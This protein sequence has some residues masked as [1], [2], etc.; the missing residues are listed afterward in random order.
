MTCV[1]Y[2]RNYNFDNIPYQ[3]NAFNNPQLAQSVYSTNNHDNNYHFNPYFPS[4]TNNMSACRSSVELGKNLRNSATNISEAQK[5]SPAD[6]AP[7]QTVLP[8]LQHQ[9]LPQNNIQNDQS[10]N[11]VISVFTHPYP[12]NSLCQS[13]RHFDLKPN[14]FNTKAGH[15][16]R[17]KPPSSARN[18][19]VTPDM[20]NRKYSTPIGQ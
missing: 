8:P 5:P 19:S 15:F 11:S 16:I 17:P 13:V 20:R 7:T 18:A 12:P 14:G 4:L 1:N 6:I 9:T 2:S 3:T 10:S